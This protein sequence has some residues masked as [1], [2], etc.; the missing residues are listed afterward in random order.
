MMYDS[1]E[2]YEKYKTDKK[3][4]KEI[5][6]SKEKLQ[7]RVEYYKQ[8]KEKYLAKQQLLIDEKNESF[9]LIFWDGPEPI[10]DK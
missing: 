1:I 5:E 3:I 4:L 10:Y 7:K 8:Q 2:T 6:K 9:F